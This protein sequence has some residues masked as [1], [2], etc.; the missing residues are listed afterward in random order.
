MMTLTL[1]QGHSGL[2]EEHVFSVQLSQQLSKQHKACL[3]LN[4]VSRD[5]DLKTFIWLDQRVFV[6]CTG[7]LLLALPGLS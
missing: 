7:C 3:G 4:P 6:V 5:L 2:A 1:M